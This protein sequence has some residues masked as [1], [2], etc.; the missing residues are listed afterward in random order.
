MKIAYY[1][2]EH[3]D[4][5]ECHFVAVVFL[6]RKIHDFI[7]LLLLLLFVVVV[8]RVFCICILT[9]TVSGIDV[10][11]LYSQLLLLLLQHSCFMS[12]SYILLYLYYIIK[13]IKYK[14]V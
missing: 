7:Y 2:N 3:G 12:C 4:F 11:I 10:N 13:N 8:V 6:K 5:I 9:E 1:E 14:I